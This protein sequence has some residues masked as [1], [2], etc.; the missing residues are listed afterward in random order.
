MKY[1]NAEEKQDADNPHRALGVVGIFI[2]IVLL[3][4]ATASETG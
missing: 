3:G 1:W 2:L 4:L